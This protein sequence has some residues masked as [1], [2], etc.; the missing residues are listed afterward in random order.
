MN[1]RPRSIITFSLANS[2]ALVGGRR[3]SR[4]Q[5][6]RVCLVLRN[7]SNTHCN[8]PCDAHYRRNGRSR[9]CKHRTWLPLL[10]VQDRFCDVT[11]NS[12]SAVGVVSNRSCATLTSYWR[13]TVPATSV[14]LEYLATGREL[15]CYGTWSDQPYTISPYHI[16]FRFRTESLVV[17]VVQSHG[18][19]PPDLA[20]SHVTQFRFIVLIGW[21]KEHSIL[22]FPAL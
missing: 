5:F 9:Q 11:V 16:V 10:R 13:C 19:L 8:A 14:V 7:L 1:A 18:Q 6:R 17:W 2:S 15:Q 20:I 22:V 3:K 4:P 12:E 21:S